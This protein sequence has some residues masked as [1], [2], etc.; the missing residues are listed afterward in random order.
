MYGLAGKHP[1]LNEIEYYAGLNG[2]KAKAHYNAEID[3]AWNGDDHGALLPRIK[4]TYDMTPSL[5][6]FISA[7]RFR[8]LPDLYLTNLDDHVSG[9]NAGSILK[10]YS[11]ISNPN[12]KFP[13]T[14]EA[15]LGAES[16]YG[17][18]ESSLGI[19]YKKINSQIYLNYNIDSLGNNFETPTNFNDTYIELFGAGKYSLGP[20]S[21]EASGSFRRWNKRFFADGPEKGPIALGFVRLSF[22]RGFFVPRLY[23]GGSLEGR[24][25]SRRDYRSIT[26]G[27]TSGFA[28]LSGRLEFRYKDFTFWLN[29]DNI[30]NGSYITWWDYYQTPRTVWWGFRWAFFD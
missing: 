30:T 9:L 11:F 10:S 19:S 21:G 22:L 23:F 20:I 26:P 12:L 28:A 14:N 1:S 27:L 8:R 16:H 25:S 7:A 24:F 18:F 29:E 13:V 15:T 6:P 3:F 5:S 2:G 4:L 17:K